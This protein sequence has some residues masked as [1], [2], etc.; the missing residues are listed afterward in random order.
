MITLSTLPVPEIDLSLTLKI[1]EKLYWC[2][3][4]DTDIEAQRA[5]VRQHH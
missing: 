3:K 1:I 2:F 5:R 4:N